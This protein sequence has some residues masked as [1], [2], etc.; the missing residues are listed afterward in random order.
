MANT[1][2]NPSNYPHGPYGGYS[3]RPMVWGTRAMVG[4]GTQLTAQAGM[5]ILWE[6]GNAVDAALAIGAS[7]NVV[8][9]AS[10]GIGGDG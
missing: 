10:S 6:G 4:A 1:T 3:H 9:P 8:E 5:R 7:L 2:V